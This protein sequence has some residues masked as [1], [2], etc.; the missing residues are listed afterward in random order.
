MTTVIFIIFFQ[1]TLKTTQIYYKY[2]EHLFEKRYIHS[3]IIPTI[4]FG[5]GIDDK[6]YKLQINLLYWKQIANKY[7]FFLYL[8]QI[9][10][11][12]KIWI[13]TYW[14]ENLILSKLFDG[15]DLDILYDS[16]NRPLDYKNF[17]FALSNCLSN[18]DKLIKMWNSNII[19][20][21]I[22]ELAI[23]EKNIE[24]Y[25]NCIM[26]IFQNYILENVAKYSLIWKLWIIWNNM[27]IGQ[28][29]DFLINLLKKYNLTDNQRN[30]KKFHFPF[31]FWSKSLP[32]W[33]LMTNFLPKR[34]DFVNK[35][36]KSD[37]R[38]FKD[39]DVDSI[40]PLQYSYFFYKRQFHHY[41]NPKKCRFHDLK[42]LKTSVDYIIKNNLNIDIFDLPKTQNKINIFFT[43]SDKLFLD[44]KKWSI[45]LSWNTKNLILSK[46]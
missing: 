34:K 16:Q 27:D 36:L 42:K 4:V 38:Y 3:T 8:S 10:I 20:H 28:I 21:P 9:H 5:Y 35:V 19:V 7:I 37:L 29:D 45:L 33:D 43:W 12:F 30:I 15:F 32:M 40:I 13:L 41:F 14:N 1:L 25:K 23:C 24:K 22:F 2:L 26:P 11:M 6:L 44:N 17:D 18:I 31:K 39:A 46:I